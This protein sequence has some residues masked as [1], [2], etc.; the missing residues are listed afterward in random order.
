MSAFDPK[1]TSVG[2]SCCFAQ[3]RF[4]T[5]DV[6]VACSRWFQGG[7]DETA[8]EDAQEGRPS[9]TPQDGGAKAAGCV[10]GF[11]RW[12]SDGRGDAASRAGQR[13]GGNAKATIRGPAARDCHRRRA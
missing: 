12:P 9:A 5:P 2:Q 3:D 1:P 8:G 6:V 13:T 11:T 4:L 10:Y 7:G